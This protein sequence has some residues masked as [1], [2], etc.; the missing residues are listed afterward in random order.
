MQTEQL[1]GYIAFIEAAEGLKNT[2]RSG[3]TSAGRQ[4]STAE[5]SWRL[6]LL[7]LALQDE[8]GG[9]DLTRILML[10]LVHDLGEALHGDIPATMN[11]DPLAKSRQERADLAQLLAPLPE[12][13]RSRLMG[14]WE[15][16]ELAATPEALFVKGL[17]KLETIIQHNQGCNRPGFDYHFNL[18]Y[19]AAATARHPLLAA[20]RELVDPVTRSRAGTPAALAAPASAPLS[21]PAE[22]ARLLA[23]CLAAC[24][25]DTRI[26]AVWAGGSYAL[27]RM[28]TFSDLDLLVVIEPEHFEAA[29]A[30]REQLAAD[31]G[32][33]L[34][35]FSG[36][37]VGVPDLL[38]CLFDHPL[39]HVDLHFVAARAEREQPGY[40]LL[41]RR[42][43]AQR[44]VPLEAPAAIA[45]S[46]P[47]LDWIEARF[48][49]WI[50][51]A[52]ARI[53][54][55]EVMAGLDFLSFLRAEVLG[56]LALGQHGAAPYGVRRVETSLPPEL[57]AML[58]ATVATYD[59]KDCLRAL[60]ACVAM[61]KMLRS[62]V[63][64]PGFGNVAA[65]RAACDFLGKLANT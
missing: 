26:G 56:P 60:A 37:H 55:G 54:R 29:R 40:S 2:L 33:L 47:D 28:D 6:A 31:C 22:Q 53:G 17:D 27:D 15:E 50:H 13:V 30:G 62:A 9:L 4:E 41:W 16:Y 3:R 65:E 49:T 14:V 39:L 44:E 24:Q 34:A 1:P 7:G 12:A 57:M 18:A 59:A 35:A 51:Y 46:R 25:A 58:A 45:P 36:E 52:A 43:A 63:A 21:L 20:L 64:G 8:L 19:G 11:H 38:I 32:E 10:C 42:A 23:Q 61:Y 48:W 5:H